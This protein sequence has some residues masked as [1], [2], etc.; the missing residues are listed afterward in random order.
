MFVSVIVSNT[1][2]LKYTNSKPD[3]AKILTST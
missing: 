3:K 2:S 1:E